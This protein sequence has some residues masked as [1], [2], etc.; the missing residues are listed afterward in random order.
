MK[1]FAKRLFPAL[2]IVM[3]G[4]W[5][6]PAL[7]AEGQPVDWEIGFQPAASSSAERIHDFHN[8]LLWI[9]TGIVIFV[10]ILLAIVILR[11][12]SKANPKPAQFSHNVL[13]E[14]VWTIVPILILIVIVVPSFKLL[15]TNDRIENPDMT[16]KVTGY[17]WYW[18]YEYPDNDGLNF[19]SYMV[20]EKDIDPA[21]GQVRLLSTDNVVVLP[22]DTNIQILV[23]AADVIHAFAVPALGVKIDAVPGRLNETW[24]N[25][26]KPGRYF[27]QC[28]ELCG[29]DHSYMPIEIHAVSKEEFQ[30]WLITAKEKFA[31]LDTGN[32]EIKF[33]FAEER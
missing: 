26:S 8:M 29:K 15:Y 3:L 12:N 1:T 19:L 2:V 27:G 18:G 23:T 4:L 24:V 11:F 7:A 17:Q 33:A 5:A 22:V 16:L 28:S 13:I 20:P 21:K 9:I 25:I 31:A 30:Q 6:A 10:F 14:V 32:T